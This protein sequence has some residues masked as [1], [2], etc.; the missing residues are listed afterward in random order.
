MSLQVDNSRK[1][2]NTSKAQRAIP[3]FTI[4]ESTGNQM[5]IFC[6]ISV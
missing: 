3:Q 5:A 2:E 4:K 1:K 6:K